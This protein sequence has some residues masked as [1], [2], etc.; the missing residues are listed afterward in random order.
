MTRAILIAL[1]AASVC[2]LVGCGTSGDGPPIGG[3]TF[4]STQEPA[5]NSD[6]PAPNPDQPTVGSQQPAAN[7]NQPAPSP[8]QLPSSGTKGGTTTTAFSCGTLCGA[9]DQA[10]AEN[11]A[12]WCQLIV[13]G[14]TLCATEASA[15]RACVTHASLKCVNGKVRPSGDACSDEG[16]ALVDCIQQTVSATSGTQV[17]P[18]DGNGGTSGNAAGGFTGIGTGGFTGIGTGGTGG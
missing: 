16:S 2:S 14:V 5:P 13:P 1:S 7:P 9:I 8:G 18:G 11:C 6:Q 12:Q 4:T 10:C 3:G 17:V 15:L